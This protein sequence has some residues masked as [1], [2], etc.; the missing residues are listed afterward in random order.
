MTRLALIAVGSLLVGCAASED[1]ARAL[2][3]DKADKVS[4]WGD[5]HTARAGDVELSYLEVGHGDLVVLLHGFPDTPHTWDAIAP[6]IAASGDGHRVVAPFLRGYA[7]SGIPAKDSNMYDLGRDVIELMDALDEDR[8]IVIG[9]DWGAFS[10]YA[11]AALE[12]QRVT[13]LVT[14]AIPHP[15]ALALNPQIL[16]APHFAE[17]GLA[18]ADASEK[19]V[20][21]NDYAY[22]DG[23]VRR[24]S[25]TWELSDAEVHAELAPVREA[26]SQPGSLRATLGYYR[27]LL[28][29]PP[30]QL[31]LPL[32]HRHPMPSMTFYGTKDGG[33]DQAVFEDQ[34][35]AFKGAFTLVPVDGVGHFVHREAETA[36]LAKLLP[37]LDS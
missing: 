22:L 31:A 27:A 11:A 37:F 32:T 35:Y 8:A 6:Q 29:R 14:I 28:L 3:P 19:F 21:E 26:V 9:H 23:L 5:V 30:V 10:A 17:L 24:W 1:D 4:V 34:H 15:R 13:K 20:S 2:D 33:V 12:P 36:F 18:S 7:P 25:P 16:P